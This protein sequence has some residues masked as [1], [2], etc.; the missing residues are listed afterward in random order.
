MTSFNAENI[1]KSTGLGLSSTGNRPKITSK[2]LSDARQVINNTLNQW[3][4]MVS[5]SNE[6][7]SMSGLSHGPQLPRD[8]DASLS[9]ANEGLNWAEYSKKVDA[10]VELW[11]SWFYLERDA[12]QWKQVTEVFDRV[13]N[14]YA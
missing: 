8:Y 3:V 10:V 5:S 11:L 12:K 4:E 14:A 7:A 13:R 1:M 9:G 6:F 2:K